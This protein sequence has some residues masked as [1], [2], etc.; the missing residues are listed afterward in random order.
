MKTTT[1]A[2]VA[3]YA[4]SIITANLLVAEYGP[5]VT[6]INAFVLIGLDLVLRDYL[7]D[8]WST[9]RA[10]NMGTLI[11]ATGAA[12]YAL[13]PA[14]GRIAIASCI[15]FTLAALVDWTIYSMSARKPWLVRSNASNT[16]GAAVD[17]LL[18]PTIAFGAVLWPIVIGQFLAKTLGGTAW[19]LA[20]AAVQ[21]RGRRVAVDHN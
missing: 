13:N 12:S 10:R 19:S 21:I 8:A 4:A 5:S 16:A 2:A 6:I 7:H 15:A 17:S 18:F 3:A 11:A 14:T 9:N 20:I 1:T